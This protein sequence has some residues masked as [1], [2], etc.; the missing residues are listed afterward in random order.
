MQEN[1]KRAE[2]TASNKAKQIMFG[3]GATKQGLTAI[4]MAKVV[5][6]DDKDVAERALRQNKALAKVRK[7][8]RKQKRIMRKD[9][10]AKIRV[11]RRKAKVQRFKDMTK[12]KKVLIKALKAEMRS[13]KEKMIKEQSKAQKK[14]IEQ[15]A[16]LEK[17]LAD[18][19]SEK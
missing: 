13:E 16:S 7:V 10:R 2:K 4:A 1:L 17:T 15:G 14:K 6:A 8:N 19:K 11:E 12:R 5:K 18:E 9:E 3:N